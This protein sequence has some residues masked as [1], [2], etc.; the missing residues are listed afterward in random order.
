[1]HHLPD[2][3]APLA[4]YRQ[5][6]LYKLVPSRKTPG[7]FDKIPT[8][9]AGEAVDPHLPAHWLDAQTACNAAQLFGQGWGVAFTITSAD[10]FFLLDIDACLIDGQWSPVAQELMGRLNGAAVEVSQSGQ[11]L[12]IIGSGAGAA[13][14]HGCKN[15]GLG[16]ELYTEAR[17]VA[18]TGTNAV[19]SAGADVGAALPSIVAQYFPPVAGAKGDGEWTTEPHADWN[20][21]EDDAELIA[22]MLSAG[23]GASAVFG[24]RASFRDLWECNAEAIAA[25]FPDPEREYDASGADASLAQHLAFWTGSNCERMER[26]MWESGLVRGKWERDDYLRRTICRAVAL[27][28]EFYSATGPAAD[29]SLAEQFGAPAL[30]ASSEAQRSFAERVR[31]EKLQAAPDDETRETLAAISS[32]KTWLENKDRTADE[33]ARAVTPTESASPVFSDESGPQVVGGYQYLPAAQQI[34]LFRGCVYVQDAH[35]LFTPRGS[36]LKSDQVNATF[37]GYVFQLDDSGERTTRKA[38]EAFTESQVVR[39]PKVEACC[40][41]PALAPGQIIREDGRLLVN[42]YVPVETPRKE[43]DPSPFLQHLEKLLPNES[44]RAAILAYMAACIQHVGNKFQ[45]A[46]LVQ[47][48]E[49]NGKTLLTRCVAHAIGQRYTHMPKAADIDNKFNAWIDRKLFIGVE[50]IYVAE[51]RREVIEALKPLITNDQSDVQAKGADQVMADNFANFLLN[52]NAKDGI[53]KTRNDRRFAIFYTAQQEKADLER[54]GMTGDYFPDLYAWLK[55]TQKYAGEGRGHGYAIVAHYLATYPIPLELNPAVDVGGMAHRAPAT[56]STEEAEAVALGSVE[57]EIMEAI[58][59]G[60]P[61]FANGWISSIALDRLLQQIRKAGA[62]PPNKRRELLQSLGYDW[63]PGLPGGRVNS[64]TLIDSG[65]PR[66]FIRQD[67]LARNL[68]S[69]AEIARAYEAAQSG[70]AGAANPV[71]QKFS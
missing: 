15:T 20:G 70:Q 7:K 3:L 51:H 48:V 34:D 36:L 17:F 62:I 66:L 45:W 29:N 18:L 57:Q 50:D 40:F 2:A 67:H 54:D 38:W 19:G 61:G 43:G 63:H 46:P 24:G 37:G 16:L 65:K 32:A 11:G 56:T 64:P 35:R 53:R 68:T 69:P 5:F 42:T 23:Q 33:I 13:G 28:D 41:R 21:P 44:D 14:E 27:Q 22:K 10:P 60:R 47:G 39:F 1:M 49:G 4:A 6:L 31:A 71:A 58:E 9:L 55:G 8:N 30:R 59:E 25:A 52:C 26:L 12:H